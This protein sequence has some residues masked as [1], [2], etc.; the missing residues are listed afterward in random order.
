MVHQLVT[1][2]VC[3]RNFTIGVVHL[4]PR[5]SLDLISK[6]EGGPP[7]FHDW[8]WEGRGRC[9]PPRLMTSG[10]GSETDD[11]K[12]CCL[13]GRCRPSSNIASETNPTVMPYLTRCLGS[14]SVQLNASRFS[15][16]NLGTSGGSSLGLL[17]W[18]ALGGR[19][20]WVV[21]L[22]KALRPRFVLRG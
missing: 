17:W 21:V 10:P 6:G 5:G 20:P 3:N 18:R 4:K 8:M 7:P 22:T 1:Q 16:C 11:S 13:L 12:C 19:R 14:V 2:A 9:D 15:S